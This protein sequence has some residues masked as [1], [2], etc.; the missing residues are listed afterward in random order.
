LRDDDG[1]SCV[2]LPLIVGDHE[3]LVLFSFE[4]K[5]GVEIMW[6]STKTCK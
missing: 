5:Y 1:G 3:E 4:L 2:G 6:C